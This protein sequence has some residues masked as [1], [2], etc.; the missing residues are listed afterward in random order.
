MSKKAVVVDIGKVKGEL[1][2]SE[3]HAAATI[4][5]EE[6]ESVLARKDRTA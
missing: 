1:A 5:D 6:I 3:S 2:S 4:V